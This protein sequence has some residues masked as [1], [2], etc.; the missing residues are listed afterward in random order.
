[1][2]IEKAKKEIK[3]R[4]IYEKISLLILVLTLVI[5]LCGISLLGLPWFLFG[6]VI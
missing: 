3:N 6:T 5:A 1:M 2:D 4:I